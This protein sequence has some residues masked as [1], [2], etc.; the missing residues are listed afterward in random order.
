M[1]ETELSGYWWSRGVYE[2][3]MSC[4][5]SEKNKWE[6]ASKQVGMEYSQMVSPSHLLSLSLSNSQGVVQSSWKYLDAACVHGN[7]YQEASD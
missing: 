5:T 1:L 3:E 4:C 7:G 6:K 2:Q